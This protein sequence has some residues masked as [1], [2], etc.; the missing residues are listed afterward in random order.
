MPIDWLML[1]IL[2]LAVM[3]GFLL[4]G[5]FRRLKSREERAQ[6]FDQRC[7]GGLNSL[8]LERS[9]EAVDTLIEALEVSEQTLDTHLALGALL[10]RKGEMAQAI[11]VHQ[12]LLAVSGVDFRQRQKVQYE[13]AL[14]YVAAGLFDRAESILLELESAA[15]SGLR[16]RSL[17]VLVEIY[18]SEGEWR[19][20]IEIVNR[21]TVK[22]L[23]GVTLRQLKAHYCCELAELA[24]ARGDWRAFL[25]LLSEA[26]GYDKLGLRHA[27]L[28]VDFE[29]RQGRFDEAVSII[30]RQVS[31]DATVLPLLG[32]VLVQCYVGLGRPAKLRDYLER[33]LG[34]PVYAGRGAAFVVSLARDIAVSEGAD[35]AQDFLLWQLKEHGGLPIL[36]EVWSGLDVVG[37]AESVFVLEEA[38]ARVVSYRCGGCGFSGVELHWLCPSCKQWSTFGWADGPLV[39]RVGA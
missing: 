19:Q 31:A 38:L 12:R 2:L 11:A 7:L 32:D 14:N 10:R 25:A 15:P 6:T 39:S 23:F 35:I 8:L 26:S 37:A 21:M 5:W 17:Q 36:A 20:A 27:W 4:G 9:G 3:L 34:S 1:S 28:R 16:E 24:R 30:K 22:R 18:Q 29:L 33:L 13:L